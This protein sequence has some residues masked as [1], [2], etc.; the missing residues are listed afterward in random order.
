MKKVLLFAF[1]FALIVISFKSISYSSGPPTAHTGAPNERVC[2]A[3][4]TGTVNRGAFSSALE[5]SGNFT[6][7]GYIPDSSYTITIR[8]AQ[9]GISRY[10]FQVTAL[11]KSNKPAG[12]MVNTN[13]RTQR[14]TATVS[15]ATRQYIEQ[16]STGTAKTG[17]NKV[18]WTFRWDAPS[19]N[20]GDI[21]FYVA[22]NAANGSGTG[23]DTIYT[24]KFTI[25]PS[26]LL[27]VAQIVTTDTNICAFSVASF[28]GTGT[29]SPTSY[30]WVF[31][32]GS[33]SVSTQQNPKVNY[34]NPG[35]Y[36][37]R[38]RVK[39]AK[40]QSDWDT[41]KIKVNQAPSAF[42]SGGNRTICKG[43]SVRLTVGSGSGF[44]YVWNTKE[45]TPSIWVK[46][47]GKYYV[48]VSNALGC[49][50]VSN[51]ITVTQRTQPTTTISSDL[52][53][54]SAC[55]G[56]L[57]TFTASQG[58][59][60]FVWYKDAQVIAGTDTNIY[61]ENLNSSG[62][63]QV[64]VMSDK[65]CWSE[66]SDSLYVTSI[67]KLSKPVMKCKDKTTS[68]ITWEWDPVA[69]YEGF[70]VST[71]GQVWSDPSSGSFGHTHTR[72]GLNPNRDYTLYVRAKSG[73][74]CFY[75]P[76]TSLVC[77]SGACDS[78]TVG[79]QY[80][81]Q[82]CKGEDV[83]ITVNGLKNEKYAIYFENGSAFT[84][85]IFQFSPQITKK[86]SLQV[87]DS[88]NLGCPPAQYFVDVQ[89]DEIEQLHFQTQRPTNVFCSY[90]TIRF[91]A[92]SG[93]DL[94][95]F[96]VN[97]QLRETSSDSFYFE[98]IF[99]DGDSAFVE[100]QK[101]ACTQ[102]SE[103]I[104]LNVVPNPDAGFDYTR[105]GSVYDF[106]PDITNYQKYFWEFGD[107]F[108]SVLMEPQ[109]DYKA[110]SGKTM[111]VNLKVTDNSNCVNDTTQRIDLPDF[112][113][114]EEMLAF[115]L[116]IYPSPMQDVLTIESKSISTQFCVELMDL[117]SRTIMQDCS[118]FGKLTL[119]VREQ[120]AGLYILRI[121]DESQN[122]FDWKVIK[123]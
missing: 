122:Q 52:S 20:L 105:S 22:L 45:T 51:E 9:P 27:P 48:I 116:K 6:G 91:S 13:S 88:T 19:S 119:D 56:T 30:E 113:G 7:N 73:P 49:S 89:V 3:C 74:P 66:M 10:G 86:Y 82:V 46:D 80:D 72:S 16:T 58:F 121:F 109:H 101:G 29:G 42:I 120:S 76:V 44:T 107:G 96:Y 34:N 69:Q 67:D 114:I 36:L 40:G 106:T 81:D 25:K 2:T 111:N 110:S 63:Y 78:L 68:S 85:T 90:D 31:S 108:T 59:D 60:S 115:G 87:E 104:F 1:A 92:S 35:T 117:N 70:Q 54:D 93:N 75:S 5:L 123:E 43:D 95:K 38:L 18:D 64:R 57:T 53:N 62:V 39:S 14:V 55:I 83:T 65:G 84:D 32:G 79:L 71:D 41:V 94:Y 4:H 12:D 77:K 47:P 118:R 102:T 99:K 37:A 24:K 50:R 61:K 97:E 26:T 98:S 33:P 103:K 21:Y 8:H 23:G 112:T 15:G 11:D 28:Q 17:T 100:V